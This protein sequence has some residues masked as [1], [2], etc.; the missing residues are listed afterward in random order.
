MG[1]DFHNDFFGKIIVKIFL[2]CEG[3]YLRF[4]MALLVLN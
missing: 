4:I 2:V 1:N 3:L